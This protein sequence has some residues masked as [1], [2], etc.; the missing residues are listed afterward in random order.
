MLG[1]EYD[2][3]ARQVNIHIPATR[4]EVLKW[5]KKAVR[6]AVGSVFFFLSRSDKGYQ[7]GFVL[8]LGRGCY[9]YI[10]PG[11]LPQFSFAF[12][13]KITR[14]IEQ[15][16]FP[17]NALVV[18]SGAV[19]FTCV[20][21]LMPKI[22]FDACLTLAGA[23]QGYDDGAVAGEKGARLLGIFLEQLQEARAR[24]RETGI[25]VIN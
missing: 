2:P 6:V 5:A 23:A 25:D 14:F 9:E 17:R 10:K 20:K 13:A 1:A 16:P 3:A 18:G 22:I 4:D 11:I 15:N 7:C 12:G 21:L 19:V 8:G 24:E